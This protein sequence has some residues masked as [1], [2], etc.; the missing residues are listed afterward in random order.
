MLQATGL[1]HHLS[2]NFLLALKAHVQNEQHPGCAFK[3]V[4]GA[5]ED[6]KA[7][8]SDATNLKDAVLSCVEDMANLDAE[9]AARM[10]LRWF[11]H[12]QQAVIQGLQGT[13]P[14]LFR[15]LKSAM[16]T[17]LVQVSEICIAN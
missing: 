17:A 2:G 11:P 8:S 1:L 12:D 16:D 14:L 4:D 3:Y 5:M 15:Y 10:V 6:V 7:G 13:R 9:A